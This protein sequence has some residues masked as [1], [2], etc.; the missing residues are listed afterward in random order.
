M[1]DVLTSDLESMRLQEQQCGTTCMLIVVNSL[2]DRKHNYTPEKAKKT[3][4]VKTIPSKREILQ[5][6]FSG[7]LYPICIDEA[8]C[9]RQRTT[10]YASEKTETSN[11]IL[12]FA[13]AH[14][15]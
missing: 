5:F 10:K 6:V 13:K 2:E 15:E 4:S 1:H 3:E 12:A 14:L 7:T 8:S 9:S 11:S